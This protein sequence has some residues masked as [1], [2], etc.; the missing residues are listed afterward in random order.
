[1]YY[2]S[3]RVNMS[4]A[5][6]PGR[7]EVVFAFLAVAIATGLTSWVE[8]RM[9]NTPLGLFYAA[10]VLT[11]R[12]AGK[13]AGLLAIALSAAAIILV[14]LSDGSALTVDSRAAVQL[15]LFVAVA[16]VLNSLVSVPPQTAEARRLTHRLRISSQDFY[17][18]MR[19][20]KSIPM[21]PDEIANRILG[22]LA[23]EA[24]GEKPAQVLYS[25]TKLPLRLDEQERIS[26]IVMERGRRHLGGN[27]A[28]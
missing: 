5:T 8:S 1:M 15:Y 9:P 19:R 16:I 13:R 18:Y 3:T 4:R 22:R 10:V 12:Y 20:R 21:T 26:R 2:P 6:F 17:D 24:N 28:L 25:L 27:A 7:S 23:A 14:F 11:G